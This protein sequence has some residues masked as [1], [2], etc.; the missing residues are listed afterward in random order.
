MTVAAVR[1]SRAQHRRA[2]CASQPAR[3]HGGRGKPEAPLEP[4][5]PGGT[6]GLSAHP[7][8]GRAHAAFGPFDPRVDACERDPM[9]RVPGT[10]RI[11]YPRDEVLLWIDG[12]ELEVIRLGRGGRSCA[13][14]SQR[15]RPRDVAPADTDRTSRHD[16]RRRRGHRRA[17]PC[18]LATR[19]PN[20]RVVPASGG[21]GRRMGRT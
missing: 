12:A 8:G 14:S 18:A 20:G 4:T 11:I 13:R 17:R 15:K 7:R 16:R 2:F 10:N 3:L 19:L 6:D 5:L 1:Y 21:D 9:R